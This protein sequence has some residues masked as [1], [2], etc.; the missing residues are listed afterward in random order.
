MSQLPNQSSVLGTNS[1]RECIWGFE[2]SME[3][4]FHIWV[5][6]RIQR[7]GNWLARYQLWAHKELVYTK[8]Y[9]HCFLPAFVLLQLPIVQKRLHDVIINVLDSRHPLWRVLQHNMW[10]D[11]TLYLLT[12]M[13]VFGSSFV[14]GQLTQYLTK[15]DIWHLGLNLD[16]SRSF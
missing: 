10:M 9:S 7:P 2:E 13:R 4:V 8:V 11:I 6:F 15:R 12:Y 1:S 3:E 14:T 16:V 5:I